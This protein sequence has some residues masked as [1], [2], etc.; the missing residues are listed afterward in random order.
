MLEV[1]G[2]SKEFGGVIAVNDLSFRVVE[3]QIKSIIGP[4]G[5][6][7]TTLF[8]L[9]TGLAPCTRGNITFLGKNICGLK[10]HVIAELGMSR[11]FQNVE[12]FD[13]MSILENVMLGRHCRTGCGV[14]NV[15]LRRKRAVEE[16]R[17][18]R[19]EALRQIETVGLDA[20]PDASPASLPF[21]KR[22]LVE[23]ARALATSPKLLLL[24]EPVSGL[25]I[26][27]TEQVAELI[28][29]LRS[30]GITVMLVEHDMSVV[31]EISDDVLV[32]DY[33]TKIAEG[34]PRDVQ[35]NEEV[36]ARYLGQSRSNAES[37]KP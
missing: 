22:R 34:K 26:R 12:I 13:N 35:R 27:E 1:N 25:N 14:L 6:G 4:N 18:I 2:L 24:D 10:P 20:D 33:G 37:T 3:R 5:A 21:G 36:I 16:E 15:A 31:M 17:K 11:S 29:R 19:E 32:M 7:K 30:S 9:L 23:F 8:N 28:R